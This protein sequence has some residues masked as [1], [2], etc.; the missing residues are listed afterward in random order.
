MIRETSELVE[1]IRKGEDFEVKEATGLSMVFANLVK[2]NKRIS[3][4]LKMPSEYDLIWKGKRDAQNYVLGI[5]CGPHEIALPIN[6]EVIEL[7]DKGFRVQLNMQDFDSLV[8]NY[9]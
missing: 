5:N 1:L 4:R 3:T 9:Y 8:I 7:T 6:Y 2:G